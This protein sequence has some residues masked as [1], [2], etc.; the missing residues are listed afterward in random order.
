LKLQRRKH[1]FYSFIYAIFSFNT[2]IPEVRMVV[3]TRHQEEEALMVHHRT[4][5]EEIRM[6]GVVVV[7]MEGTVVAEED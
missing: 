7:D 3:A 1:D 6:E 2:E 5:A 4:V